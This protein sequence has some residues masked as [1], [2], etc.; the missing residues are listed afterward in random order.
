MQDDERKVT[1]FYHRCGKPIIWSVQTF[2]GGEQLE[3]S[4]WVC[5]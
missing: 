2:T 4:G 1:T 5:Y 3:V